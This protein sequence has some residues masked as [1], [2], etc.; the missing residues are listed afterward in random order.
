MNESLL[1]EEPV[2]T[3]FG[4]ALWTHRT[5][6]S[7]M[8]GSLDDASSYEDV[9]FLHEALIAAISIAFFRWTVRMQSNEPALLRWFFC[10]LLAALAATKKK[11][12]YE[13]ITAVEIF[14][15]AI[16]WIM[17]RPVQPT[18]SRFRQG[19]FRLLAVAVGA[20]LS[21]ALS[22][23]LCSSTS[24][25]WKLLHRITPSFV[26]QSLEY[27][28]PVAEMT[29]AYNIMGQFAL[30][31]HLYHGMI[32]HLFFVTFHIQV[33]MGFLGIDFLR[34]EQGR[35]NQLIRLDVEDK[36][37]G[38]EKTDGTAHNDT[39]T[40]L[41]GNKDGGGKKL[42][43][44]SRIFQRGAAP[45]SKYGRV[46]NYFFVREVLA[47]GSH[48]PCHSLLVLGAALPYMAQ[49]IVYGSINRFA[50]VCVQDE[51]HRT[52]RFRQVFERENHLTTMAND[53]PTSP[54]GRL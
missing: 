20:F 5:T 15:Y 28:F 21:M 31:P 45:F 53:S 13:L 4:L 8:D 40:S 18:T 44:K 52:V 36:E 46:V 26:I 17:L 12:S 2:P 54:E 10:G 22:H 33:G 19:L 34:A 50:Y 25:F 35:R 51:L 14:S 41:N 49:I 27:L 39:T 38:N 29:A 23:V 7:S 3:F 42:L 30:E 43:E 24:M 37:E 32:H 1:V 16:V 48:W 47:Q 9:P 11:K 6:G